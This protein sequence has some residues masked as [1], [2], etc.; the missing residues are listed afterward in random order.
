MADIRR[1]VVV[2]PKAPE[3]YDAQ[4]QR[5][6]RRILMQA[7][8]ESVTDAVRPSLDVKVTPAATEYEIVVTWIGTMSY[9]IDGGVSVAG[10]TSPQTFDVTRNEYLGANQVYNFTV[11]YNDQT[12]SNTVV[13]PPVEDNAAASFSIGAQS[14]NDGT[15][16]YT[17]S[18][19]ASDM[20]TGTTFNLLYEYT[21]TAGT[22]VEKGVITGAT[23]GGTIISGGTI[24]SSPTY[25]MTVN[26]VKNGVV[27]ATQ[28]AVGIF[29][30]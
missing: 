20:P 7:V 27:V 18:W 13:V 8:G 28:S 4:E 17:Y 1:P 24:G 12:S 3:L 21:N 16:V 9:R 22:L 29:T 19:T 25:E 14:A 10:G 5:E 11:T 15:N 26:A 6:F 23:S 2:L 30:T